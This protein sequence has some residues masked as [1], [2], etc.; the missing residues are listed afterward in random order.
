MT[1]FKWICNNKNVWR[2]ILHCAR[3]KVC[4]INLFVEVFFFVGCVATRKCTIVTRVTQWKT[5]TILHKLCTCYNDK[6]LRP[7][8]TQ[9]RETYFV[10]R[11]FR[12]FKTYN[13]H[14]GKQQINQR[15][16]NR[17]ISS[18]RKK[19]SNEVEENR[20]RKTKNW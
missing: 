6:W 9:P 13:H 15:R 2:W 11:S 4:T 19:T 12:C 7:A 17:T 20:E 1:L 10:F 3:T 16:I 14:F 5:K 8:T 18:K